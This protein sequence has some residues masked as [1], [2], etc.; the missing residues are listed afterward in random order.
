MKK[1]KKETIREQH[2]NLAVLH[3]NKKLLKI[4]VII[5][6]LGLALSYFGQEEIGEPMLWLGIIIFVYTLVS[7]YI[8]RSALKKL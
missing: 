2:K 5:L 4:N 1:E 8:A 3:R 7:N 6:S